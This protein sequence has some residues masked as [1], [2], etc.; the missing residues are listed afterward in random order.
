MNHFIDSVS[1]VQPTAQEV[2]LFHE[3]SGMGW[4]TAKSFL[5]TQ[6]PELCERIL[7]ARRLNPE[8]MTLHDPLEDNPKY[9]QMIK[10]L[11]NS[12]QAELRESM[13]SESKQEKEMANFREWPLGTCH[14]VWRKLKEELASKGLVWYSP[15]ELNPTHAFD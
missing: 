3:A 15:A 12:I 10:S 9:A 13:I 14:L 11:Y 4:M 6:S 1:P 2:K 8:A 5:M 7:A